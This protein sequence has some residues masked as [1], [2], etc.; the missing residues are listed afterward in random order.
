MIESMVDPFIDNWM[1]LGGAIINQ[2]VKDYRDVC[3]YGDG[4]NP[5]NKR[6][7]IEAF[8]NGSLFEVITGGLVDPDEFARKVRQGLISYRN[9]TLN[10]RPL[11]L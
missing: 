7:A 11:P 6:K 1:A 5:W 8:F 10:G 2:A 3:E 4:D 9:V